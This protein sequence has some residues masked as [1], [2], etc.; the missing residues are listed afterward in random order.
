MVVVPGC[1]FIQRIIFI[2]VGKT[3]HLIYFSPYTHLKIDIRFYLLV[4]VEK[5]H[6]DLNK[7]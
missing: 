3:Y 4:E 5:S 1:C 2:F 7:T 6:N